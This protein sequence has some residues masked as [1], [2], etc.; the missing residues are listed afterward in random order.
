MRL[1]HRLSHPNLAN[2]L[3]FKDLTPHRAFGTIPAQGAAPVV[4]PELAK[5]QTENDDGDID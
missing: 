3:S 1:A 2:L 5:P 4:C